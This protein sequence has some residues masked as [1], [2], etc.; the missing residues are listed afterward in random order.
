MGINWP[1]QETRIDIEGACII[2][3]GSG[4]TILAGKH[5]PPVINGRAN[6][7]PP[8]GHPIWIEL[9]IRTD[10]GH[11]FDQ[12]LSD[13]KAIEGIFVMCWQILDECSMGQLDPQNN[14]PVF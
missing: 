5:E 4:D 10:D 2:R 1:E 9:Y 13:Q 11:R 12:R 6:S 14:E 8:A 3:V 7:L